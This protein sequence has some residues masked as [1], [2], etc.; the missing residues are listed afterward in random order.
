VKGSALKV[1][2]L[3]ETLDLQAVIHHLELL[4]RHVTEG[5]PAL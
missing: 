1:H 4:A 2:L 5:L 3:D